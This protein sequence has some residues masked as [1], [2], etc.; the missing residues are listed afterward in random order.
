M[1]TALGVAWQTV[2][3][4]DIFQQLKGY[5]YKR[6]L[7]LC[8]CPPIPVVSIGFLSCKLQKPFLARFNRK[9]IYQ[10]TWDCIQIFK[11]AQEPG[12]RTTKPGAM[13]ISHHRWP[14]TKPHLWIQI[15]QL[16]HHAE[17]ERVLPEPLIF[18]SL[19]KK[20][21]LPFS[22]Q[23]VSVL[24]LFICVI[25][26]QFKISNATIWLVQPGS[27]AYI[28]AARGAEM[29]VYGFYLGKN[30]QMVKEV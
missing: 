13:P 18:P 2:W 9:G 25:S 24:N 30:L 20:T 4:T 29:Q 26:F 22:H 12:L 19:K 23:K 27:H 1:M 10:R 5:T 3:P 17:N 15:L 16:I 7:F 28:L 11:E 21:Y 6:I 8:H 14:Q